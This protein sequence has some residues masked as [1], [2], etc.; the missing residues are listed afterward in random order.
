MVKLSEKERQNSVNEVRILASIQHP[1]IVSYKE[2]FFEDSTSCLCIVMDLCDGGD[3]LH[4][5]TQ[6]GKKHTYIP[7][8]ECW[9]YFT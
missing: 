5:I 4:K 1:N 3:L 8:A 9:S 6:A 7:E 2:S